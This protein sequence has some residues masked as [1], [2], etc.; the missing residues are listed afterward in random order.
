M[1]MTEEAL[2]KLLTT[3]QVPFEQVPAG[4]FRVSDIAETMK[5]SEGWVR[6]KLLQLKRQSKIEM[7]P[8]TITRLDDRP[9]RSHGYRIKI[10]GGNDARTD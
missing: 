5:C 1:E 4:V 6:Q 10:D 7:V 3:Y 8:I 2:L 9:M